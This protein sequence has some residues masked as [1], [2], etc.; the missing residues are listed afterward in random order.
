[1][2]SSLFAKILDW[3][4][5]YQGGRNEASSP[6]PLILP[7]PLFYLSS[8]ASMQFPVLNAKRMLDTEGL[9]RMI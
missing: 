7:V 9:L 1:M 6:P 8:R 2:S 4:S 5:G 3:Y